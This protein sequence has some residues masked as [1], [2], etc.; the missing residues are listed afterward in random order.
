M[1]VLSPPNHAVGTSIVTRTRGACV[2]LAAASALVLVVGGTVGVLDQLTAG[3]VP[4]GLMSRF[5]LNLEGGV[6][7]AWSAL[8]LLGVALLLALEAVPARRR[9]NPEWRWWAAMAAVFVAVGAEEF[10]AVH[11]LT[12]GPL[13]SALGVGG[14]LYYAWVVPGVLVLL[15]LCVVFARFVRR[16]PADVRRPLAVGVAVMAAGA[17]GMESVGGWWVS[18]EGDGLVRVLIFWLEESLELVGAT[19]ALIGLLR[20]LEGVVLTA[21][22]ARW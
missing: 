22:G 10:L 5:D 18:R 12:I 14:L 2:A 16:M 3:R 7:A 9:G 17:L 21:P 8:M 13:R 19:I 4:D 6:P 1:N 11:E 20:R 15:G